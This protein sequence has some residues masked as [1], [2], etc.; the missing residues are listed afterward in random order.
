MSAM[1]YRRRGGPV[2]LGLA[3]VAPV[4]CMPGWLLAQTPAATTVA[5]TTT[6]ATGRYLLH[7]EVPEVLIY[8]K[9]DIAAV[10]VG[11]LEQGTELESDLKTGEW[12]RIKR[13]SG[14][15]GW[16]LNATIATGPSIVVGPFPTER[17]IA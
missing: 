13:V 1:G 8:E 16:V 14:E 11:L 9:P 5:A 6:A 17:R 4:L 15:E 10:I 3:L 2:L 7:V 12:Y